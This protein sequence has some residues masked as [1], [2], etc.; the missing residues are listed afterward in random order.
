MAGSGLHHS[1]S[2]T[3]SF[4]SFHLSSGEDACDDIGACKLDIIE[5]ILL[6]VTFSIVSKSS[7]DFSALLIFDC[8]TASTGVAGGGSCDVRGTI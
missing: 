3:L 5:R 1:F 8:C 7:A 6:P 4:N 2:S